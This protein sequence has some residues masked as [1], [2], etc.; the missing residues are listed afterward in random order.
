MSI[1]ISKPWQALNADSVRTIP[2]T[3]GVFELADANGR[4]LGFGYAGASSTFGLRSEVAKAAA[5]ASDAAQFRV[6]VTSL[7]LSRL[8]ELQRLVARSG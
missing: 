1:G 3:V 8:K 2:P 6:E 7:Y 5:A 4:S